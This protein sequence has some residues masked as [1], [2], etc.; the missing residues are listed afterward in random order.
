MASI[1][2]HSM[3]GHRV[4]DFIYNGHSKNGEFLQQS[5]VY[6][7]FVPS[8]RKCSSESLYQSFLN[9]HA[10]VKREQELQKG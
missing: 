8:G 6:T 10:V 2:T 3:V 4:N 1:N 5:F 9:F 7:C